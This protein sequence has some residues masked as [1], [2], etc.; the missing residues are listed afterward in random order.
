MGSE[1]P[2]GVSKTSSRTPFESHLSPVIVHTSSMERVLDH[3]FN[4]LGV[5]GDRVDH[6]VVM[7]EVIGNPQ[8]SRNE[9][10]E[11]LFEGYGVPKAAFGIDACFSAAANNLDGTLL[12]ISIGNCATH[13]LPVVEGKLIYE[14]I[15]RINYGGST[16]AD[17]LLRILQFKYP[18]FPTRMTF[19]QAREAFHAACQVAEDYSKKV[20]QIISSDEAL[21]GSNFVLQFPFTPTDV[22]QEAAKQREREALALKRKEQAE[23]LREK[24]RA[25]KEAK[26]QAKKDH[27][28]N[29]QSIKQEYETL[30]KMPATKSKKKR[31]MEE[32]DDEDLSDESVDMEIFDD[33]NGDGIEV[34][35][36]HGFRSKADLDSAILESEK[37]LKAFE[38]KIAG[39]EE[40]REEPDYS[41]LDVP[42]NQLDEKGIAEKRKQ[43][44]M[45]SNA[46]ARERLKMA[47]EEAAEKEA[48]IM[49]ASEQR[50]Q[51]DF[52]CWLAD[53]YQQRTSL[54]RR[55]K[56]RKSQ[57]QALVDRKSSVSGAR[58]RAVVS[59]G[60][61]AETNKKKPDNTNQPNEDDGFGADDSDWQIYRDIRGAADAEEDEDKQDERDTSKLMQIEE[62]LEKYD[63]S[64]Y[65]V[66]AKELAES[67]T[68][69]DKLADPVNDHSDAAA[70]SAQLHLNVERWR[71]PE[72]L[73]QPSVLLG[74]DTAGLPDAIDQVL[75]GFPSEIQAALSSNIFVCGGTSTIP[76]LIPRLEKDLRSLRPID[77]AVKL[78]RASDPLLDAWKGVASLSMHDQSMPWITKSWYDEHGGGLLPSTTW[79]TNP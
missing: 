45:K 59:L 60:L 31:K 40:P 13:I 48:A 65:A 38:N 78:T 23:R 52:D 35:E 10:C 77:H 1:V 19:Q 58:L 18:R 22:E 71:V 67:R 47:K 24:A 55:I 32:D 20:N 12:I 28:A 79:Y 56:E 25:K 72:A 69:L 68:I 5:K 49:A 50:R 11:L 6:G 74:H 14:S 44:L 61:E 66:L 51:D 29:L 43:R 73:F 54:I 63:S 15:E 3:V 33:D 26:L 21:K 53:L 4:G 41:L 17:Y 27:L 37:D 34:L 75:D 62:Q 70:T 16:A 76:G 2:V 64:F 7:T 57:R 42:D 30:N 9:G 46:E 8:Y 39:V 36:A